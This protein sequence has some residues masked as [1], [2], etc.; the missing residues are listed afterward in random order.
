V[1][2]RVEVRR[3]AHGRAHF[4]GVT[5]CGSV[6]AC[7]VCGAKI[8]ARRAGEVA[9]VLSRHLDAG[10]GVVMLT[11]TL[12]H[13]AGDR[14]KRTRTLAAAA[15]K[16]VAQGRAWLSLR[17]EL[18]VVGF[19]RALE[20]THGANGW[21]P[22][23]HAL[24]LTEAPLTSADQD[25]LR[26]HAF[27]AWRASVVKHGHAAPEQWC[28]TLTSITDD[29]IAHYATKMGAALELTQGAGKLG[30]S[31]TARTPFAVAQDYFTTG[32]VDDLALWQEWERDMKGARQLT[33][34]KGLKARY[35]L[36]ERT[37]EEL[38]AAEVPDAEVVGVLTAA[39]WN[40]VVAV[41]G[42]RVRVLEAAERDDGGVT[43]DR[44]LARL[45]VPPELM[46][47]EKHR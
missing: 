46:P 8:A 7:P 23:V 15:W 30:R 17:D 11:L 27:G 44:L 47:P 1:A 12:P 39:E 24:V 10:G 38:S 3:G 31:T 26:D 4:T 37:D 43:L 6:W 35:A 21:H 14:L 16:R 40:V 2:E 45:R 25:A 34:S 9:L 32:D 36:E 22:H 5:S 18:A 20:V 42:L 41:P 19:I 28:T 29:G 33:W 13:T